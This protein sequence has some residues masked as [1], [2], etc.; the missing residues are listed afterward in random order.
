MKIIQVIKNMIKTE[1]FD[2]VTIEDS[3][4][5][6]EYNIVA[7][8][9]GGDNGILT[10]FTVQYQNSE[11]RFYRYDNPIVKDNAADSK[12]DYR[13]RKML[14]RVVKTG[15]PDSDIEEF[16]RDIDEAVKNMFRVHT[17]RVWTELN[18]AEEIADRIVD[19]EVDR[20]VD[21]CAE[22]HRDKDCVKDRF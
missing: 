11:V 7:V 3:D 10:V 17:S 15:F 22:Y 4:R 20:L 21:N 19:V 9:E 1:N 5:A 8:D 6:R 14:D 16:E 12:E 2:F 13:R 18:Y